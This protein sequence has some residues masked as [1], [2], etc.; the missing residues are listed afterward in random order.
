MSTIPQVSEA[1]RRVLED[2]PREIE[3]E[4]KF[5]QRTTAKLDGARFVQCLVF[6]WM[7]DPDASYTKLRHVAAT[8]GTSVSNQ[9]VEQR[10]SVASASLLKRV[11]Q[12]AGCQLICSQGNV[13]ELLSRFAGVYVQDGSIVSLPE[14]LAERYA[15]CGGNTIHAGLSSLRIQVRWEVGQGAM[16]G[17]WLQAGRDAERS[18]EAVEIPMPE[19]SLFIGDTGYFSLADMRKRGEK[20]FWL[21]PAKSSVCLYDARGIKSTLET[22]LKSHQQDSQVDEW[23]QLGADERLPVRLIAVR[24]SP[25][26]A[27]KRRERA[28]ATRYMPRGRKGVQRCGARRSTPTPVLKKKSKSRHKSMRSS[29]SKLRLADW[30]ILLSNV[31]DARLS[32]D[33]ALVL[34]RLRWQEELLWKLWKQ[35]GKIDTWR[36]EK[37]VRIET[38]IYAKLLALLI[39]H[40]MDLLGCWQDPRRSLR[41][42]QQMSQ[43]AAPVLSF[44]LLGEM[45]LDRT[46]TRITGAMNKGCRIDSRCSRFNTYQLLESPSRIRSSHKLNSS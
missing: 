35:Y 19:G 36:S 45:D 38:E 5:V 33:E 16:Q 2:Y 21:T 40:W 39:E 23:V 24:T 13:P 41:K 44:A 6:G 37:A 46:I 15:G 17:P 8:Q 10:F 12:Q 43:W 25:Q 14:Q 4:T 26:Q 34:M 31:P 28:C 32:V 9:A 7:A 42:A 27:Q 1:M 22:Y 29:A 20:H 3:R 18:G 30:T 11:L